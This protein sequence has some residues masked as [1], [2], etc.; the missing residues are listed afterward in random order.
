MTDDP[1]NNPALLPAGYD[2]NQLV[3]Y[4][5]RNG[6]WEKLACKVDP[7]TNTALARIRITNGGRLLKVGMYAQARIAVGEHKGA[8]TVPPSAVRIRPAEKFV[9]AW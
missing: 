8:L 6:Q 9:A 5:F 7:A 2:E 3:I 1:P 4:H